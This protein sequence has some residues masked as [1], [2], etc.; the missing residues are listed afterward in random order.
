MHSK[1][2]LTVLSALVFGLG[3]PLLKAQQLTEGQREY[4]RE[5]W[6]EKW[7]PQ[8]NVDARG[9]DRPADKISGTG[10]YKLTGNTVSD[11]GEPF[12]MVNP[13]D[14]DNVVVSFMDF[15]GATALDFPIYYTLDGGTTWNLSNF[16][17]ADTF[18]TMNPAWSIG[19]GGDPVFA[20]DANG[21]LYF[22]WLYLASDPASQL[23][24]PL[25][26]LWAW[27]DDKGQTWNM[28]ADS[29]D[30]HIGQGSLGFLGTSIGPRGDGV[31]D[32]QWFAVDRT[33][34]N[35]DGNLYAAYLFIPS[36]NSSFS[37]EGICVR[38][39]R[40]GT[41]KWDSVHVQATPGAEVQ[42]SNIAVDGNGRV[43]LSYGTTA[44][45]GASAVQH[46]FSTDGGATWSTPTTVAN[47]NYPRPLFT[48][49]VHPR[50]N[51]N[52]NMAID[53]V[54]N[55]IYIVFGTVAGSSVEGYF[56]RSTDGGL[57]WST[58]FNIASLRNQNVQ[59]LMPSVATNDKGVVTMSWFD[60]NANDRGHYYTVESFDEGVTWDPVT[61]LSAA[62]SD[63]SGAQFTTF[64]G[65]Y[66]TSVRSGCTTWSAWSDGRNNQGPKLYIAKT[67][68]CTSMPVGFTEVSPLT[69]DISLTRL[70]PNP[71]SD[72]LQLGLA[73]SAETSAEIALLDVQG[74]TVK[75]LYRGIL[76]AGEQKLTLALG[77]LA[78]GSY[79]LRVA[80]DL[81]L[82]T[83]RVIKQ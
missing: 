52:P 60:L 42:F 67:T 73:L 61:Q 19:G 34:G 5:L 21:R 83:R 33:G 53:P 64:Y 6:Q 30:R 25:D 15:G 77:E 8:Q 68:K 31:F 78:A 7:R 76:P 72:Q 23:E 74:R 16:S 43:H 9:E 50:E 75:E 48:W 80:T 56:S 18:A 12:I 29:A 41:L 46:T 45:G 26:M 44:N 70:S 37:G 55:N 17:A 1:L 49:N 4:L 82:L 63:F 24:N 39:M 47:V 38:V 22:S 51:A 27:S 10:E 54:S 36:P 14:S 71:A 58:P 81:G 28:A 32:R 35:F 2:L 59:V 66:Y 69:Q 20:Y 13:N 40:P 62:E 11:E 65:D 57:N 3:A 79:L